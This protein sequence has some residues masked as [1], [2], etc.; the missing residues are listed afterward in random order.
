[1]RETGGRDVD[2]V[3]IG[4]R[5]DDREADSA[6]HVWQVLDRRGLLVAND[7]AMPP[8]H[9]VEHR[10]D[11]CR[12]LAQGIHARRQR[13]DRMDG[14]EPA[15]LASHVVRGRGDRAERRPPDDE[16]GAAE[17]HLIG[18]VRVPSRELRDLHG[19]AFVGPRQA[20]R[21]QPFTQ[22]CLQPRPLELFAGANGPGVGGGHTADAP[23]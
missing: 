12:I 19:L 5:V 23:G 14:R 17:A 15:I 2:R 9:H 13:K 7:D 11:D 3:Q 22:P 16:L 6:P 4:Q 20:R 8:L 1:M 10:T 18:Q 21:G